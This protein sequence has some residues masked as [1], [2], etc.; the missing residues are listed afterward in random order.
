MKRL[1]KLWKELGR[2]DAPPAAD[3]RA[4][5]ARVNA[6]LEAD[7]N[8][9]RIHMR[10]KRRMVLV[11][12]A[13]VI[14]ATGSALAVGF[15]LDALQAFFKG[16][17]AP[18]QQYVNNVASSVSDG[19]WTFTVESAAADQRAAYLVLTV[20]ALNQE[21]RDFL[22]SEDFINMDT[23]HIQTLDADFT[24]QKDGIRG[25]GNREE[26]QTEDSITWRADAGL[27]GPAAYVRLQLDYM[28]EADAV[29]VALNATPS[30]TVELGASGVGIPTHYTLTPGTLTVERVTLTP[31]T[32]R[33]ETSDEPVAESFATYPRLFF[34]LA[35]GSIRTQ[36]QMMEMTGSHI[37][38]D[39][40]S[41]AGSTP[42]GTGFHDYRFRE[43]QDLDAIRSVIVFDR[44]FPLDGSAPTD[45][46]HD[47][48][49]DPV[50][51]TPTAPLGDSD[52]PIPA[53][54]LTEALGGTCRRDPDT[55]ALSCTYR[56][57]TIVLT[58]GSD[59]ADVDGRSVPLLKTPAVRDGVLAADYQVFFDAWGLDGF[60]LRT[61]DRT[62]SDVITWGDWYIMP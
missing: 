37:T 56:G 59:T 48:A 16:D 34:R 25:F 46:L 11:A 29:Q 30:R 62:V 12:A 60:V 8:E 50:R 17:T 4:V 20:T 52:R 27:S 43:V 51:V 58:P 35:D 28:D 23:F 41:P 38:Q 21:S 5:K 9:R 26:S 61:R 10:K 15:N 53:E 49:L 44:E 24:E 6:A 3:V 18:G 2:T 57:V 42:R 36:S 55:G 7:L 33:V 1:D 40:H 14:A 13:L 22:F 19:N 39:G 32:C 31:F 47:P 45:L 54:A